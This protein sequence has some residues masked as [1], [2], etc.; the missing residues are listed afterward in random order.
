MGATR[1][2]DVIDTD[3]WHIYYPYR[4]QNRTAALRVW[5]RLKQNKIIF[6]LKILAARSFK[7]AV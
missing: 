4:Q 2:P 5:R 3:R 6:T 7:R 1:T